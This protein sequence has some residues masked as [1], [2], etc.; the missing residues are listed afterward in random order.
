MDI[1]TTIIGWYFIFGAVY[2]TSI[3]VFDTC[4]GMKRKMLVDIVV[5]GI[6]TTTWPYVMYLRTKNT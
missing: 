3:M 6:I 4:D 1:L 2:S 5:F